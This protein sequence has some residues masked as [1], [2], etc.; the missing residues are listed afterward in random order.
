MTYNCLRCDKSFEH[1]NSF[2]K[3]CEYCGLINEFWGQP[4][5]PDIGRSYIINF[6]NYYVI[7]YYNTSTELHFSKDAIVR[8][9]KYIHPNQI[10]ESDVAKYALLS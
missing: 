3:T 7:G 9:Q 4:P 2:K 8:I 5:R 1:D 6:S 10:N